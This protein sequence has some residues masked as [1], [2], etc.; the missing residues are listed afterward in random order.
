MNFY[1]KLGHG[2]RAVYHIPCAC[3]NFTYTLDKLWDPGVTQHQQPRYQAVKYCIY[4][5]VVGYFNNW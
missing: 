4:W 1:P 3:I 2:T 5:P